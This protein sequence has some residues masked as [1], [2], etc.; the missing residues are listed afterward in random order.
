MLY[1]RF[2][3]LKILISPY[4]RLNAVTFV[5]AFINLWKEIIKGFLAI[6]KLGS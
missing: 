1:L 2:R 6:V 5:A 4:K 3:L